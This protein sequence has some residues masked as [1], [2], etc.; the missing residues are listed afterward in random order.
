MATPQ[1]L[2]FEIGQEI[3]LKFYGYD[4][5]TGYMR[6]SRKA[7]SSTNATVTFVSP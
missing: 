2:G 6:L 4:P 1:A 7:I 3:P 5:A